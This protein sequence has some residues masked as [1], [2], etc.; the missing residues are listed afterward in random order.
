MIRFASF[1]D[2]GPACYFCCSMAQGIGF[3]TSPGNAIQKET[4]PVTICFY[5]INLRFMVQKLCFDIE[6]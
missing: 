3:A 2:S 1:V 6:L 4:M 5:R